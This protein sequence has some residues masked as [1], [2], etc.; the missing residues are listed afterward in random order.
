MSIPFGKY[1]L[2]AAYEAAYNNQFARNLAESFVS[3]IIEYNLKIKY[4]DKQNL[5]WIH[6]PGKC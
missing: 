2:P 5:A 3:H 6:D 4:Y 1:N